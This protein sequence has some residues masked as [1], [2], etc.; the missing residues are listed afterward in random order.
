MWPRDLSKKERTVKQYVISMV[1]VKLLPLLLLTTGIL[2]GPV[3][4][5]RITVADDSVSPMIA[6]IG[7]CRLHVS[8]AAISPFI[9]AIVA[10]IEES[11]EPQLS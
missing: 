8:P 9:N 11:L 5:D 1:I 7:D 4:L 2:K 10:L 6:C 3:D